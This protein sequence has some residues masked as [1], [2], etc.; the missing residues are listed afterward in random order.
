M[1][2]PDPFASGLTGVL[3]FLAS[4]TSLPRYFSFNTFG[5]P[6]LLDISQIPRVLTV[7]TSLC[8]TKEERPQPSS[9]VDCGLWILCSKRSHCRIKAAAR[10]RLVGTDLSAF[11]DKLRSKSSWEA[12]GKRGGKNLLVV[13]NF[14]IWQLNSQSEVIGRGFPPYA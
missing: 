5:L 12:R 13:R 2:L 3:L 14:H 10:A 8:D 7:S 9:L 6:T 4:R 11:R 1:S